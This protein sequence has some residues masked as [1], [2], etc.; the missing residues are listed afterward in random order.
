VEWLGIQAT[1][2]LQAYQDFQD[3]LEMLDHLDLLVLPELLELL[4]M[5]EGLVNQDHQVLRAKL[6]HQELMDNQVPLVQLDQPVHL[7]V[8]AR[9]GQ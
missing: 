6:D 8:T 1:K 9:P 2:E 7:A 5:Q 4:A 3:L